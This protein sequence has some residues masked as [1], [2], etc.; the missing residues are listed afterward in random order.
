MTASSPLTS[1]LIFRFEQ[2]T[3]DLLVIHPNETDWP[4]PLARVT[5]STL[6]GMSWIEASR[7]IGEFVTLLMPPLR[8]RFEAEFAGK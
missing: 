8:A 6:D 2:A 5:A 7:F 3:G 1:E 4:Q